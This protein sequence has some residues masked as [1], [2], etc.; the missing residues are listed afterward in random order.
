LKEYIDAKRRLYMSD[1]TLRRA[2]KKKS[3]L[4]IGLSGTS[5]SGKTYSALLLAYGL[6]GDW[7]KIAIIDSENGSADLYSHLGD[8]LVLPITAPFSPERYISAIHTCEDAGMQAIII[9]SASHEWEGKGGCLEIN[10]QLAQTKF[11]GNTWSAWSQT[12]PRHQ[13]FLEAM[14]T[15]PAHIIT[16][17][18]AKQDTVQVEGKVKK[19]GVKEIQR[20]GYEYELTL[21]FNIDRDNHLA[22]ASK[23]RTGLFINADPFVVTVDTG[24]QLRDWAESGAPMAEPAITERTPATKEQKDRLRELIQKGDLPSEWLERLEDAKYLK[25]EDVL[26]RLEE[27]KKAAEEKRQQEAAQKEAEDRK[28]ILEAQKALDAKKAKTKAAPAAAEE[29]AAV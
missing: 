2:E 25:T 3:R 21:N 7:T 12:T 1:F 9:D 5:G 10:E 11:K 16:T 29:G 4:R 14:L 19:V 22:T 13:K 17:A 20:E 26:K 27:Q 6:V 28:V 23:D 18:R 24:K 15:S 8:Y